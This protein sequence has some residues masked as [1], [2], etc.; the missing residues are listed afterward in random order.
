MSSILFFSTYLL[1]LSIFCFA[2]FVSFQ[3][4]YDLWK[5]FSSKVHYFHSAVFVVILNIPF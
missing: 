1:K 3:N 2:L 4:G 5:V